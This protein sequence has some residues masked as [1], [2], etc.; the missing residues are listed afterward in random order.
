MI[1]SPITQNPAEFYC[2]KDDVEYYRCCETQTIFTPQILD[3][4][5][6]VGGEAENE[7]NSIHN[8]A[9]IKRIKSLHLNPTVLDFGCGHGYFVQVL[10]DSGVLADGYDPFNESFSKIPDQ[11]FDIVTII[12]VVE[13][14]QHPYL[15]FELI[16]SKLK[17]A[18]ILYI[19][20]SFSD[21]VD[22]N[23]PYLNPKLGH[24]T[25]FSHQGLDLL[26]MKFG[27]Q[28][29]QHISRNVRIYKKVS[30]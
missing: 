4:S 24:A 14:L 11:L 2:K 27:F 3:Q 25:I 6:K 28:A 21:W 1:I 16:A 20:T 12:E 26:L 30:M 18:G 8:E 5:S 15:E 9:R 10:R 22:E 7:R 17:N 29:M 23:H 19:E 13:H